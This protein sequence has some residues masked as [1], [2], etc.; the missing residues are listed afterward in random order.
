[1][2]VPLELVSD[3]SARTL[4]TRLELLLSVP[5]LVVPLLLSALVSDLPAVPVVTTLPTL[6][7]SLVPPARV[8]PLPTPTLSKRERLSVTS[9]TPTPTSPED[10]SSRA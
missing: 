7:T 4:V 6:T 3:P 10:V 5:L 1:M 2:L 9:V 8:S